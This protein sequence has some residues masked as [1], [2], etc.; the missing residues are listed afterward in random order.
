MPAPLDA[1]ALAQRALRNR[2]YQGTETGS[3]PNPYE[4]MLKAEY[5]LREQLDDDDGAKL[6]ELIRAK[7]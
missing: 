3:E 5:H 7:L 1:A 4:K 2:N 6:A